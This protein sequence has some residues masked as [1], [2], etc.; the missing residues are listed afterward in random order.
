M[1]VR[2]LFNLAGKTALITGGSRGLGLQMA[3]ALGEMGA[4]LAIT[5]RKADELAQAVHVDDALDIILAARGPDIHAVAGRLEQAH[6][7]VRPGAEGVHLVADED[8]RVVDIKEHV[9]RCSRPGRNECRRA[10][11]GCVMPRIRPAQ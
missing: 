4:R 5:A 6:G 11:S 7:I 2:Q 8:Q 3:E 1:S 9:D 10:S